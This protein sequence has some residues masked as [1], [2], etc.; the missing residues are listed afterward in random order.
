MTAFDTTWDLLKDF[1]IAPNMFSD[2]RHGRSG[3]QIRGFTDQ[4]VKPIY[5]INA[6]P[7]MQ[8]STT[9]YLDAAEA[10]RRDL[11]SAGEVDS[12]YGT[13]YRI[14]GS[15]IRPIASP[16]TQYLDEYVAVNLP[17]NIDPDDYGLHDV[18][19]MS[20]PPDVERRIIDNIISTLTHEWAHEATGLPMI[21]DD[22][23]KSRT[24]H[25]IAAYTLENPGGME[26]HDKA[27]RGLLHQEPMARMPRP[28][29]REN[30]DD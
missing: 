18:R 7:E 25:E 21:R 22:G 26:A 10:E 29:I 14:G 8:G 9:P 23:N 20:L 11:A 30:L 4:Q 2:E 3:Y 16:N 5:Q 6:P 12:Y 24:A 19:D 15:R 1:V 28:F 27:T 17:A 13:P